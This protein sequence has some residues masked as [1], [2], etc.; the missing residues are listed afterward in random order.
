MKYNKLTLSVEKMKTIMN[1][2]IKIGCFIL[3]I[4]LFG[5]GCDNEKSRLILSSDIGDVISVF[6]LNYGTSKEIVYKGKKIVFAIDDVQDRVSVNCSLVDFANN[7]YD[8]SPIKVCTYLSVNDEKAP[9]KVESKPCGAIL[10][11]NDGSDIQDIEGRIEEMKAASANSSH[12]AYFTDTFIDLFGEGTQI[13]NTPYRI[14]LAKAFPVR[15]EQPGAT[16]K[17]YKFIFIL[18]YK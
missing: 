1:R 3:F 12:E 4:L 5:A 13:E 16:K 7:S 2:I 15:Y 8:L 11:K 10:Y 6:E 17:D 14:Y 18:T 9:L